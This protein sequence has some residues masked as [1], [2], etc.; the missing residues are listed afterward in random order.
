[1]VLV[2]EIDTPFINC[3]SCGKSKNILKVCYIQFGFLKERKCNLFKLFM[4]SGCRPLRKTVGLVQKIKSLLVYVRKN[5]TW[6]T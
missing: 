4:A 3:P 5:K 2:N 6:L 1:M